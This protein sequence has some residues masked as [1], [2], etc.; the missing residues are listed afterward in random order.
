M[1]SGSSAW[2]FVTSCSFDEATARVQS[3]WG[4]DVRR[5]ATGAVGIAGDPGDAS[6]AYDVV[7][8][9]ADRIALVPAGGATAFE[10][11]LAVRAEALGDRAPAAPPVG[12]LL[13]DVEPAP[14][15]VVV[16]AGPAVGG[17]EAGPVTS[18]RVDAQG[19]ASAT[20]P[21]QP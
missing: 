14:V 1:P 9:P 4:L 17:N 21:P 8:L 18:L 3:R 2:I 6:F 19:V 12:A 13:E 20:L 15:R 11:A 7:F 16:A 10:Q 5:T